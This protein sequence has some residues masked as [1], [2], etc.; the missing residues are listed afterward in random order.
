MTIE[1]TG[2]FQR[3]PQPKPFP[4][5]GNFTEFL[6]GSLHN[7]FNKLHKQHGDIFCLEIFSNRYMI[8]AR[9]PT[10]MKHVLQTNNRNY[11]KGEAFDVIR[12]LT[13]NGLFTSNGEFWH[14]QRRMIQP[15]FHRQ[16]IMALA[17]EMLR[18]TDEM[19]TTWAVAARDEKPIQLHS[20][21]RNLTMDIV[22]RTLFLNNLTATEMK[23]ISEALSR[24]V[25]IVERRTRRL[26]PIPS[27]W[28]TPENR[29][30]QDTL[31][32]LDAVF[33]R[34]IREHRQ[35]TA[36]KYDLLALLLEVVDA[37]TGE[38]MNDLQVRDEVSTMFVAGHETTATSLTWAFTLLSKH[39]AAYQQYLQ[40]VDTVVGDRMITPADVKQLPYTTAIFKEAMRLY[41][42]LPYTTRTSIE[43]DELD[44]YP[45]PPNSDVM[46]NFYGL[47]SH[48]DFWSEPASFK[49]ERFLD[50][51]AAKRSR[52]TYLPFA[53]GP[54]QCIGNDFALME[55]TLV[56]AMIA[57]RFT[58]E[59]VPGTDTERS[60][61]G[62]MRPN[63]E[64][65]MF[66]KPRA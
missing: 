10:I 9:S 40:E 51:S 37:D 59:L 66:V 19:L 4:L 39:P 56:M 34:L 47:H 8:I 13:G 55:A 53:G 5:L 12:P 54:R 16:H 21:M 46:L 29:Q 41:T 38:Q 14:R 42:P 45:I 23:E 2:T 32:K 49:P 43:A 30:F 50:E 52:F 33:Y 64:L 26:I 60:P 17:E 61:T 3:I 24:L 62:Y 1:A 44:G 31:Q 15:T 11:M 6:K 7:T 25:E 63:S 27:H 18:T 35:A 28:P 36:G 65:P 20:E 57:Q 58:L 48:P 22:T